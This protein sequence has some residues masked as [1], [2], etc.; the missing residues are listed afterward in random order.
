MIQLKFMI[1]AIG[2]SKDVKDVLAEKCSGETECDVY[3]GGIE[4]LIE[5]NVPCRPDLTRYLEV[6][7]KCVRP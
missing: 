6:G 3:V 1:A 4:S 5:G 2:C 7:Y